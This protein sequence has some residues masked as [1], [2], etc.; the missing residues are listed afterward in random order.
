MNYDTDI[1]NIANK[2]IKHTICGR[3]LISNKHELHK[4]KKF[5]WKFTRYYF[6]KSAL[7]KFRY[8]DSQFNT[9]ILLSKDVYHGSL[10]A[11]YN[12]LSYKVLRIDQDSID[13]IFIKGDVNYGLKERYW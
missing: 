4:V 5:T 1:L 8:V 6:K 3:D 9:G 13:N 11:M 2:D 10:K 7:I 12:I